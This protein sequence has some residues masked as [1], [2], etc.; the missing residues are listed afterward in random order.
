MVFAVS[1]VDASVESLILCVVVV[2][3]YTCPPFGLEGEAITP[4]GMY[5]NGLENAMVTKS[6]DTMFGPVVSFT[7]KEQS[8]PPVIVPETIPE[9]SDAMVG[10]LP[11]ENIRAP[12]TSDLL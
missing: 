6:P 1:T 8:V 9:P 5:G 3:T 11:L 4:K 10:A 12:I 2:D 7:S